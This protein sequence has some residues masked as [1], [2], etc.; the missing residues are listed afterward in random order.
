MKF[1]KPET[2][3]CVCSAIC[4]IP[5]LSH[6]FCQMIC[7]TYPLI[8]IC[9]KI[10]GSRR[11]VQELFGSRFSAKLARD[12]QSHIQCAYYESL[13]G[14]LFLLAKKTTLI[15][16]VTVKIDGN[17]EIMRKMQLCHKIVVCKFTY[18]YVFSNL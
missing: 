16:T 10:A 17:R 4:N 12:V 18:T 11:N 7:R 13:Q 8:S 15:I 6:P 1:L 3:I 2:R 14:C 9:R 5:A